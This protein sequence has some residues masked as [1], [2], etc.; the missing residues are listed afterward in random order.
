MTEEYSG[1]R[2]MRPRLL[3]QEIYVAAKNQLKM[4][5][6]WF[7]THVEPIYNMGIVLFLTIVFYSDNRMSRLMRPVLFALKVFPLSGVHALE[8]QPWLFILTQI[9]PYKI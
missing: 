1:H 6:L 8:F 7:W 9:V 4:T 3:D 2:L 5:K